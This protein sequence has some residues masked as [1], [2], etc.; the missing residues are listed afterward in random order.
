[1]PDSARLLAEIDALIAK[2]SADARRRSDGWGACAAQSGFQP[3]ADNLAAYLALR[4]QDLRD[5]QRALMAL[6]L[7]SLG[8]LESRVMPTLAAVRTALAAIAGQAP[9]AVTKAEDFFAGEQRLAARASQLFG[10]PTSSRPVALLVTCPSTAADDGAFMHGLAA[11]KVEAIRINCAH[12]GAEQW[13]GMIA[14]ARAAEDA[15]GHRCR[16]FMD[17]AGPKIRTGK[18]QANHHVKRLFPGDRIAMVAPGDL[19]RKVP[20]NVAFTFECTLA[21]IIPAVCAG[22]RL[23]IDDG[24]ISAMIEVAAKGV[25]IAT[26]TRCKEGGAKLKPERGINLPDTELEIPALTAKDREDLAFVAAH[27]DGIEFSFVQ[28]PADVLLLQE[29]L[30]EIRP[31]DWREIALILKI[32]TAEAVHNL[33]DIIVAVGRCQPVAIMI[34]RGDLAIEIGFSRMAEMQEEILWIAEAAQVPV[35]WATQVLE[36]M[37][38][39]GMPNRGELTDAA[40]AARAECVMLNKGP[41]LFEA[42][43]ALELLLAR[44]GD[45]MHKKTPQLRQLTSWPAN[46]LI[47]EQIAPYDPA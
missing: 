29:A 31:A 39:E 35:I 42:I 46:Q 1:M 6:G 34:A 37:V 44:M 40:M 33:P 16:V 43:D 10:A 26:V 21:E 23:L 13:A 8:R 15:C 12:D 38:K 36:H 19:D 17:L 5:M 32:E 30:A 9:D 7:S 14:H 4:Q 25:V 27:A 11:R 28:S 45:H 47:S 24:K 3:S 22:Q 2:V 41:Y 20:A 18:V